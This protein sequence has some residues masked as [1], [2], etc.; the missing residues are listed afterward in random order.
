MKMIS[1]KGRK[2]FN[3]RML[4]QLAPSVKDVPPFVEGPC[5]WIYDPETNMWYSDTHSYSANV[6]TPLFDDW[7][8]S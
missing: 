8:E 7:R 4:V 2:A 6:C 3:G 1:A 5:D